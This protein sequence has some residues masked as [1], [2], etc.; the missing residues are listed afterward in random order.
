MAEEK[1]SIKFLELCCN[2]RG[3][4]NLKVYIIE[5]TNDGMRLHYDAPTQYR[6]GIPIF[7]SSGHITER[8]RTGFE[9]VMAAYV[10]IANR[11]A[12]DFDDNPEN[13]KVGEVFVVGSGA[14]MNRADSD[15]DLML[16]APVLDKQSRQR[17]K[18]ILSMIFFN[19]RPKPEAIDVFVRQEDE[20]P[21]RASFDIT[22]QVSDILRTYNSILGKV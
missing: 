16:M 5:R 6:E 14:R 4:T 2:L 10:D 20:Y 22:S 19:D 17:M 12:P 1:V 21:D 13:Y 15:L 9:N 3:V 8:V 11:A 18:T 7:N